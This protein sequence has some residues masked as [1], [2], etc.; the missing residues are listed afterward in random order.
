MP[1]EAQPVQVSVESAISRGQWTVNGPVFLSMFGTPFLA[2]GVAVLVGADHETAFAAAVFG[3]L[4]GWFGAWIAWSLL[5]PRWRLWA[6]QRVADIDELKAGA[7]EAN[8]IWP[9][10]HILSRTEI[11]PWRLN[12][13]LRELETPHRLRS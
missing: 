4:G 1:A 11:R 2:Y 13:R 8:L 7:V 5:V 3:A 10:N 9:D 12:E 6:Y